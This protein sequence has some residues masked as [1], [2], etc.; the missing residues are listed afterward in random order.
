ML[1]EEV[2]KAC[3]APLLTELSSHSHSS[4]KPLRNSLTIKSFFIH[5]FYHRL[6]VF[7]ASVGIFNNNG[8]ALSQL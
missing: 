7:V 1:V 5:K 3:P 8:S 2:I 6:R 4:R